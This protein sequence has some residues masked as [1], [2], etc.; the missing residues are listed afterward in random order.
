MEF[1]TLH[2][3]VLLITLHDSVLLITLHDSVLHADV[4]KRRNALYMV[5][6]VMNSKST[7]R[8]MIKNLYIFIN[9]LKLT[10]NHATGY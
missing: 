10:K 4:K 6:R 5:P 1:I 9:L 8:L 2:D 3:S 7:R